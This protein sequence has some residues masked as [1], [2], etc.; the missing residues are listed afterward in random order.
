MISRKSAKLIGEV[1]ALHFQ[2][3]MPSYTPGMLDTKQ[4]IADELND[5]LFT[6]DYDLWFLQVMRSLPN[7]QND[8]LLMR[9]VM[10]I[11]TGETLVPG[12]KEWTYPNRQ[13]LGQTI[14]LKMAEDM[15]RLY[16]ILEY[17][18]IDYSKATT[19]AQVKIL[20]T[21]EQYP[22]KAEDK[23]ALMK[24]QLEIEGYIYRE[25]KLLPTE[26]SVIDDRQEQ[27]YLETLI[28]DA[29]FSKN[30]IIL[31]HLALS[32]EHYISGKW[33]D[34]SSNSRNFLESLL[35]QIADAISIKKT[36]ASL[37]ASISKRPKEV[38]EFLE[39]NGF[40]DSTERDAIQKV[41]GLISNTGSHPNMAHQDQARLM[42]NL[43]LTFSQYVLLQWTGYLKNNP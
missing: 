17:N 9:A 39:D 33:G 7:N 14:L 30:N 29:H 8:Q 10:G 35:E 4:V 13:K 41:Y 3:P 34:S 32:E 27:T 15:L 11:H 36:G 40:I 12:T 19:E 43:A 28:N 26:H 5:F 16:D 23:L 22:R 31:H 24:S 25:G 21:F 18:K 1:Y 2:S 6:N 20:Q 37:P 38:R 42:R